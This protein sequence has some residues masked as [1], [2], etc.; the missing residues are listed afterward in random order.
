L[1][2][3]ASGDEGGWDRFELTTLRKIAA[4]LG[5][6]VEIR[7][8]PALEGS[9]GQP[10]ARRLVKLLSPLFWDKELSERDLEEYQGW[11]IARAL[12]FGDRRQ[13]AAVR[14]FFGDEAILEAV[15]RRGI[16]P[17][18]RSYWTQVLG[19]RRRA[20]EGPGR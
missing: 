4:A 10:T 17:R 20:P 12:M 2:R 13:A 6:R 11:V 8:V 19:R 15:E 7:L 3:S 18:T 9:P 5:A 16:D 1:S 14:R